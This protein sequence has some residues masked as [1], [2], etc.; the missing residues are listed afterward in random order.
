MANE[1]QQD[2]YISGIAGSIDTWSKE[3]TQ[4]SIESAIKQLN[5]DSNGI[6]RLLK[7]TASGVDLSADQMQKIGN[8]L[9]KQVQKI[10]E[11]GDDANRSS[12]AA[13]RHD[14]GTFKALFDLHRGGNKKA[15]QQAA[16]QATRDK[17]SNALHKLGYSEA[18]SQRA[19][20]VVMHGRN[21][22]RLGK[23][24][25]AGGFVAGAIVAEETAS[26][27]E[28][29]MNRFD[30]V[31]DMRRMGLFAGQ[32]LANK[33]FIDIAKTI[34]NTNF[35]FGE[36]TEFTK[37]F[38]K[39]V[40]I[41]GAESALKFAATMANPDLTGDSLMLKY[42]MLFG[43]VANMSGSYL[44]SLRRAGQ[45]Q[46]RSED[47]LKS[48]MMDF[49]TGVET[50]SNVLKISMTEAADLMSKSL[51]DDKTGLLALLDED[52]ASKVNL[53][54]SQYDNLEGGKLMD[55]LTG[56][57]A[58]GSETEFMQTEQGQGMLGNAFDIDTLEYVASLLPT[59]QNG[60]LEE[61]N[62]LFQS[63]LGDF[64]DGQVDMGKVLKT[65]VLGNTEVQG[66]LGRNIKLKEQIKNMNAGIST[67]KGTDATTMTMAN[68][69]ARKGAQ[70]TE[71]ADNSKMEAIIQN[72]ADTTKEQLEYQLASAEFTIDVENITAGMANVGS[73]WDQVMLDIASSTKSGLS[74]VTNIWGN[75]MATLTGNETSWSQGKED[76][77]EL[78]NQAIF[79][80]ADPEQ[81][82]VVLGDHIKKQKELEKDAAALKGKTSSDAEVKEYANVLQELTETKK[83]IAIL[84]KILESLD[85]K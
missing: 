63:T 37:R 19:A 17:N 78:A 28:G 56:M 64:V 10:E 24:L 4:K 30:M 33:G 77:K 26:T 80:I 27:T 6:L 39:A 68:E 76:N 2:V 59:F 74:N 41:T 69:V 52:E 83:S 70:L 1:E 81:T 44:E 35:T 18:T 22:Q 11:N 32:E 45:L 82:K 16:D 54:S 29:A 43:D 75:F 61:S 47:D 72:I 23:K 51:S 8:T 79:S 36:A 49:M 38:S 15:A 14:K 65:I 53:I 40:G 46:G 5:A 73:T 60:S 12:E 58:A 85:S 9:K 34:S 13:S 7:A 25:L 57:L 55:T 67:K 20:N 50:T 31:T 62:A 42:G 21:I 84:T 3:V 66:D 71:W 48:G